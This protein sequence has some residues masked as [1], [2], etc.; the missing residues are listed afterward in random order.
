MTTD[1]SIAETLQQY[2][3]QLLADYLPLALPCYLLQVDTLVIERKKLMPVEEYLLR[4]IDAGLSTIADVVAFLG[5]A[6]RYADQLIAQLDQDEYVSV[7]DDG[8]VRIRPR[9]KEILTLECEKR[10]A[11]RSTS[12]IWD[13]IKEAPLTMWFDLMGQADVRRESRLVVV[14]RSLRLPEPDDIPINDIQAYRRTTGPGYRDE[15]VEDIVRFLDIRRRTLRYRRGTLLAYSAGESRPPL[16][17]IAIDGI[18]DE[19]YSQAF[20]RHG[21]PP[22][23]G[24]DRQFFRR[25]GVAGVRQRVQSLGGKLLDLLLFERFDPKT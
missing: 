11:E 10:P 7:G 25:H 20:A 24:I 23:V 12:V 9:G 21:L 6:K 2:E 16:V 19:D 3:G 4:S 18:V 22:H 13:P 5:L 14:P 17:K 1:D 8:T 15:N